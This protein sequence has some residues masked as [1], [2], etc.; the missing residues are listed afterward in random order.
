MKNLK[1]IQ[2]LCIRIFNDNTHTHIKIDIK[3]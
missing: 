2:K 3:C 1:R